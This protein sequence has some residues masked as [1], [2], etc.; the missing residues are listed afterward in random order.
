M[1]S[2][3]CPGRSYSSGVSRSALSRDHVTSPCFH[4]APKP[5]AEDSGAGPGGRQSCMDQMWVLSRS[6]RPLAQMPPCVPAHRRDRSQSTWVADPKATLSPPP[7]LWHPRPRLR[8]LGNTSY[9]ASASCFSLSAINITRTQAPQPH[10][11]RQISSREGC[12]Q[13]HPGVRMQGLDYTASLRGEPRRKSSR[14][15]ITQ[16]RS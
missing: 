2:Q 16:A 4:R 5:T 10:V 15:M 11:L 14:N 3:A 8:F 7:L 13:T 9:P 1:V 12:S 6:L